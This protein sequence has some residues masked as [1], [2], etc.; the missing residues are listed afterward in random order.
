MLNLKRTAEALE[1]LIIKREGQLSLP[2]DD[3]Q[4]GIN[5]IKWMCRQ[6]YNEQVSGATA[7]MWLGYVQGAVA[8]S[9]GAELEEL[10]D[11]MLNYDYE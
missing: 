3:R 6:I 4:I 1:R 5:H 2:T 8:A 10:Q 7:H 11:L 9:G